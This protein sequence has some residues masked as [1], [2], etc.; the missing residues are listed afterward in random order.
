MSPSTIILIVDDSPVGRYALEDLLFGQGYELHFATD[1]PEALR[2]ASVLTPDLI[3][4]D[5]MMP[6]MD[7]F[8]VCRRLRGDPHL[9]EVPVIMVTA[10]DDHTSRLRGIDAGADDFIS[11]P[12]NRSELWARV[13]SIIRLNRYRRLLSE[14]QR[15]TWVVERANEGYLLVDRTDAV[16]YANAQARRLLGLPAHDE[17]PDT[18]R[19]LTLVRRQYHLEP[20]QNWADWPQTAS[21]ELA[22]SRYLV[23]PET[24]QAD[25]LWLQVEVLDHQMGD[26]AE[27]LICLR[28]ITEQITAQRDIRRFHRVMS[29]KL[30]TPLVALLGGLELLSESALNLSAH[31]VAELAAVALGGAQRLHR[32]I[33]DVLHYLNPPEAT[34]PQKS[35]VVADLPAV[36]GDACAQ[37]QI[38]PPHLVVDPRAQ[39]ALVVLTPDAIA[40]IVSEILENAKKFHPRHAPRIDVL[41]ELSAPNQITLQICDD[42]VHIPLEQI[43]RVWEPYYQGEKRFTGEVPG[44]GLGLPLVA[45]LVWGVGGRCRFANREDVAGVIVELTL[46]LQSDNLL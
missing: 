16:L 46:P 4:L 1:G 5:V 8:E 13:K 19:F 44:M 15:F 33:D 27:L 22:R 34:T 43:A 21:A 39:D 45:S 25:A 23:H 35:F 24:P 32:T 11:K 17:I 2:M 3:L 14:R 38:D 37:F 9:G 36:L 28:N 26:H 41:V 29:H 30:N 20:E 7:G 42:G 12:F 6:L 10:L 18:A 40:V 31:E